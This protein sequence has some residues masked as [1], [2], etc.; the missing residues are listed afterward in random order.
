MGL[1]LAASCPKGW[2]R[3]TYLG[4]V[5]QTF[6]RCPHCGLPHDHD[7]RICPATGLALP[8]VLGPRSSRSPRAEIPKAPVVPRASPVVGVAEAQRSRRQLIGRV[9]GDKYGVKG[10]IGE[11]GMGAVYEAEHLAIGRLVAVKVLH[12]RHAQKRDASSRL[13]HEARVVGTIGHPNIC[14]VYDIG[15]LDDGSPYLVMERLHGESLAQRIQREGCVQHTDLSE[16][17]VQVLS[18]LVVAHEKGIV[19]RDL[20]PDNIFLSRRVGMSPIAKLLDFGISKACHI[21]DPAEGL[22]RTG[23]VMGTPYYMAPEQA[24]GDRT[25]DHRVDLWAVGI[26]LYEAL[27]GRR[28]FVARNYNALLVQILTSKHRPVTDCKPDVPRELSQIVDRALSKMR[29]GRFQT[30]REFQEKLLSYKGLNAPSVDLSNDPTMV[31]AERP[32]SPRAEWGD[33]R[34]KSRVGSIGDEPV[35]ETLGRRSTQVPARAPLVV[36]GLEQSDS[37]SV[38]V[39]AADVPTD[40]PSVSQDEATVVLPVNAL[41]FSA[42]EGIVDD[43]IHAL[44]PL[45]IQVGDDELTVVDPPSF[46]NEVTTVMDSGR[47]FP[48]K[49]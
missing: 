27:A 26:V 1:V 47:M 13:H 11:G 36:V 10:L 18:A 4:S 14:E 31:I 39:V 32:I 24:R 35:P 46:L 7:Q 15:R 2:N 43:K 42:R 21:D 48:G 9:I 3:G 49:K 17:M 45:G 6:V 25:L 8:N 20:K 28:P 38:E 22:T 40:R 19:H 44:N 5:N 30:A 34:A 37:I 12:P 16:I 29:E 41:D 23:M 33:P